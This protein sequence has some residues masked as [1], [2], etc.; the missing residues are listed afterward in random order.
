MEMFLR[1]LLGFALFFAPALILGASDPGFRLFFARGEPGHGWRME[2]HGAVGYDYFVRGSGD[3]HNWRLLPL[4]VAGEGGHVERPVE[5]PAQAMFLQLLGWEQTEV[6]WVTE[7]S[8]SPRA[9]YQL[10]LSEALGRPVSFHIYLP[11]SYDLQPQRR[12]PVLYWLHGSG[13]G[14]VGIPPIIQYFHSAIHTRQIPPIIIVF[15]NG[16]PQGMWVNAKDG[17]SPV[18]AIVIDELIHHIDHHYRTVPSRAGRIVEGFSMGGYG[19]AR[20]GLKHHERFGAFSMLGSGPMHLDFLALA[21]GLVPI[22][23][24]RRIFAEVYGEDMDYFVEQSPWYLAG[25]HAE[26]VAAS[27]IRQVVGEEDWVLPQNRFFHERLVELGIAHEYWELPGVGHNTMEVFNALGADN[28]EF[29]NR[30]LRGGDD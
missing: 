18:E 30:F 3:L 29:Y 5:D 28:F 22:E 1:R 9:E 15:P 13:P 6:P 23:E 10:L 17:R 27:V 4:T 26:D 19:A 24:R 12:F 25:L 7:A 21:P 8:V 14:V 16:L 20:F 11:P 2:W